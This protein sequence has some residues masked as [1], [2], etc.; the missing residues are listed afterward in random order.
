M[1]QQTEI[2]T[3]FLIPGLDYPV[4]RILPIRAYMFTE[5]L[6][7]VPLNADDL[8]LEIVPNPDA[9]AVWVR[10]ETSLTKL[11]LHVC[12]N[13]NFPVEAMGEK[14]WAARRAASVDIPD[15]LKSLILNWPGGLSQL[16]F[17][18]DES[19][20]PAPSQLRPS[21]ENLAPEGWLTGTLLDDNWHDWFQPDFPEK[22]STCKGRVIKSFNYQSPSGAP[23]GPSEDLFIIPRFPAPGNWLPAPSVFNPYGQ[24]PNTP[25]SP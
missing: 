3:P 11:L 5:N 23:Q 13:L 4:P 1:D 18:C 24:G 12:K 22:K 15:N 14:R 7:Y 20:V 10:P 9:K 19:G 17:V 8:R 16:V 2:A 21:D 6:K 25:F